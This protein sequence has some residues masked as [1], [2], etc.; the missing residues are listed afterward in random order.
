MDLWTFTEVAKAFTEV[1]K[2]FTEV[3][4]TFTQV[5]KAF[6]EVTKTFTE[7]AKTSTEVAKALHCAC[8]AYAVPANAS[9]GWACTLRGRAVAA[10]ASRCCGTGAACR[11]TG[12]GITNETAGRTT[13]GTHSRL[14][15]L[16]VCEVQRLRIATRDARLHARCHNHADFIADR[17]RSFV[18]CQQPTA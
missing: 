6:T 10:G 13:S 14:A 3:A 1:E 11:E 15:Q 12:A 16:D 8:A 2:T 17:L 18:G 9:S 5:A 7:V 4:K